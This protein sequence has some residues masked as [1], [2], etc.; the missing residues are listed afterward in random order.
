MTEEIMEIQTA[1]GVELGA[2]SMTSFRDD[3]MT[4]VREQGYWASFAVE[5]MEDKKNLYRARNDNELLKD[6]GDT[7][8]TLVGVVFDVTQVNDPDVGAKTL[9]CVHLI[10]QTGRVYQSSSSGVVNS[11]CDIISSFGLPDT[12]DEPLQVVCRETN[13]AKGYRYK[14]LSVV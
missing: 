12:W 13:T 2:P 7:P 11:A 14:Y 8:I 5:T 3:L 9:P 6:L 1:T 10:D 4:D